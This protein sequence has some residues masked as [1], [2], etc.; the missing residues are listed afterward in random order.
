MDL[1]Q[2]SS[3]FQLPFFIEIDNLILEFTNIYKDT[4]QYDPKQSLKLKLKEAYF[5]I[6]K[7]FF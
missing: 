2:S 1:I 5:G 7:T 6:S 3:E 4:E